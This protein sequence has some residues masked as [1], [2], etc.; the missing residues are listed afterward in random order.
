VFVPGVAGMMMMMMTPN[1]QRQ[2]RSGV[3]AGAAMTA[4]LPCSTLG[5]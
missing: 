2:R 1:A 4:S 5:M 3:R